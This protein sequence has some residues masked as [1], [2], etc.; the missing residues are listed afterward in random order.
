MENHLKAAERLAK[1]L[2]NQFNILGFKFGLNGLLGLI[3]GAGDLIVAV[4]SC[5]IVWIGIKMKLP[6][7]AIIEMISNVV[8]NFL[9]GLLPVIGDAVD[10]F[11][12]ANLKNVK[13]LKGYIK[14]GV[15]EGE[16]VD[17]TKQI[18]YR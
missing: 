2:D 12:H 16:I 11:N 7:A 18:S 10:F 3:P 6:T 8:V 15:I 14:Q 17:S 9:I 1:L 4:V 5:Y 13:I